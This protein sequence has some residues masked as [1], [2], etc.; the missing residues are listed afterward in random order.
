[1]FSF[2]FP[3]LSQPLISG[4]NASRPN[5]WCR[6]PG[7]GYQYRLTEPINITTRQVRLGSTRQPTCQLSNGQQVAV[8]DPV[9]RLIVSMWEPQTPPPLSASLPGA[10]PLYHCSS[11]M[12][13]CYR[14]ILPLLSSSGYH[15]D[16]MSSSILAVGIVVWMIT[17]FIVFI[18]GEVR[19]LHFLASLNE[20]AIPFPLWDT[21]QTIC[22]Q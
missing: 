11:S 6:N 21:G 8:F 18:Q 20:P 1:M 7:G 19:L 9:L 12:V 2:I 14:I 16:G 15:T 5:I 3:P 22:K 10:P 4:K 17:E 13:R